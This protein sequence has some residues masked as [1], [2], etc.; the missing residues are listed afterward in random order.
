MQMNMQ[1]NSRRIR[2][3]IEDIEKDVTI[4]THPKMKEVYETLVID[5]KEIGIGLEKVG[6]ELKE[7]YK[8]YEDGMKYENLTSKKDESN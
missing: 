1:M 2:K 3:V 5:L 4:V 8:K 6:I 7:A